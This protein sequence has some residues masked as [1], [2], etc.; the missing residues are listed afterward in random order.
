[1]KIN[2][3]NQNLFISNRKRFSEQLKPQS[4]AVFFSADLMPRNGDQFFPF[5]QQS[6][7]FYLTGIDQ[8]KSILILASDHPEE[9]FREMLFIIATNAKISQWEGHKYS[10]EEAC[11]ISGIE[12]VLW[13]EDLDLRLRH[14][15]QWC[16]QVYLN[17]DENPALA[18]EVILANQRFANSLKVDFPAHQTERSA[19][20]LAGLRM[21]KSN[22]EIDFIQ[23]A[24]N[25]T[26]MA[27]R[28][29]LKFTRVGVS[30]Y[31]IQAEMEHVFAFN[32]A[33]G[34]AYPPIVAAGANSCVLH[35]TKN[36]KVCQDGDLLLLDFGAEYE[37]YAAD[38]SRTIPVNGKFTPRQRELYA[39]VLRLQKLAISEMVPGN[40]LQKLNA[41]I[42]QAMEEE[43]IKI[44]LLD[45]DAVKAQDKEKPLYKKYFMH[46]IGHHLGLDVHDACDKY[47]PFE[48]GMVLTCEPGIYVPEENIGIRIENN[49]LITD[50]EPKDLSAHIPREIDELE[51]L[52]RK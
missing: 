46:G 3:L 1:L 19:P 51:D 18:S 37:Y 30:E 50:G 25:I 11:K 29:I 33:R 9:K 13:L 12:N 7:F 49:I 21:I 35:Y 27:F 44:G 22:A 41:S 42:G 4:I 38:I 32:Q 43:L 6:D 5:R 16:R 36:D 40:T 26:G 23:Q 47:R 24:I 15:M 17:S 8:E 10:Q 14:V 20:I 52:M 39:L 2:L 31:Q 34:N 45:A 28:R 48:P